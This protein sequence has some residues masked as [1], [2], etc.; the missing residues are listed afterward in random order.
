MIWHELSQSASFVD[1]EHKYPYMFVH[2]EVTFQFLGAVADYVEASGDVDFARRHWD[3]LQMAYR[4]CQSILDPVTKLPR[5][6]AGKQGSN[7]QVREIDELSLS[8]TWLDASDAF[9]RLAA[10]TAHAPEAADAKQAKEAAARA[11]AVR[12]WTN[13]GSSGLAGTPWMEQRSSIRAVG[14]AS[15]SRRASSRRGRTI[16]SST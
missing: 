5:I 11:I 3:A 12:Y 2:V 16:S 10:W 13:P 1:W 14:P 6:A 8:S 4:Y 9:S 15:C 7:E